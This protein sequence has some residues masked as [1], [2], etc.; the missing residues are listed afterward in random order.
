MDFDIPSKEIHVDKV[1]PIRI[2]FL[3][4]RTGALAEDRSC[5]KAAFFY[6]TTMKIS[7]FK[8]EKWQRPSSIV[9]KKEESVNN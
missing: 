8:N 5:L 7:S 3:N 1:V 4:E 2:A 9:K 6:G